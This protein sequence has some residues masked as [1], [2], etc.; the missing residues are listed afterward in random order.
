MKSKIFFRLKNLSEIYCSQLHNLRCFSF[1][2]INYYA[3]K[4]TLQ[5]VPE[6]ESEV[7]SGKIKHRRHPGARKRPPVV[8]PEKLIGAVRNLIP[9][10]KVRYFKTAASELWSQLSSRRLPIESDEIEQRLLKLYPH[11]RDGTFE[12][13][14]DSIKKEEITQMRKKIHTEL[15]RWRPIEYDENNC[16]AYLTARLAPNYASI[17][18]VFYE[19]KLQLGNFQPKTFFDFGSG[20]GSGVWAAYSEFEDNIKE[21]FCV[22]ASPNMIDVAQTLLTDESTKKM[23]LKSIFF[24]QFLP[25]SDTVKYDLVLSA[26]SL[27]ELPSAKDRLQVIDTLWRKTNDL[28]VIIEYGNK[29]GFLSVLDARDYILQ[30]ENHMS[31]HYPCYNSGAH[32]VAPCTHDLTCPRF[33]ASDNTCGFIVSYQT[34]FPDR[35]SPIDKKDWI[36]YVVLRKGKRPKD[37]VSWPRIV[38][39]VLARAKHAYCRMCCSDGKLREVVVTKARHGRNAYRCARSSH[40]GDLLPAEIMTKTSDNR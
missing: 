3:E 34:I 31:S 36:S 12:E 29:A 13:L 18:Q 20:V 35:Y 32:V 14:P 40:L 1:C 4:Y 28:L 37:E 2:K 5:L 22:D 24:R 39:P 33:E 8:L 30:V 21:Y 19:I 9:D 17:S 15:Y 23:F 10:E 27:L 38:K 26:F 7:D 16:L 11:L 6:V 25:A